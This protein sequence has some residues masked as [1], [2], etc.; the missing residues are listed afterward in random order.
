[1]RSETLNDETE[2]HVDDLGRP[3]VLHRAE[4]TNRLCLEC[5]SDDCMA[6]TFE[7]DN[8]TADREQCW[9]PNG[10]TWYVAGREPA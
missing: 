9:C 2:R 8:K 3:G 5:E 6:R 1:M 4:K 7:P 10:H